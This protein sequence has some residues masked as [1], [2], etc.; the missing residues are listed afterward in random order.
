MARLPDGI[1]SVA[2]MTE[3]D[4][5]NAES[6]A[7]PKAVLPLRS[8]SPELPIGTGRVRSGLGK[9]IRPHRKRIPKGSGARRAPR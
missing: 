7:T 5:F 2:E 1:R 4:D 3:R 9:L 6:S 8:K